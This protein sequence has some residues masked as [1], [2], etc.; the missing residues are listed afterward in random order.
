MASCVV[1]PTLTATQ[2]SNSQSL[3]TTSTESISTAPD[4]VSTVVISTC[5]GSSSPCLP[6]VTTSLITSPGAQLIFKKPTIFV[7]NDFYGLLRR[8]HDYY[9]TGNIDS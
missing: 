7:P 8:Y 3:V 9:C 6:T 5:V 1:V 2:V 4:S